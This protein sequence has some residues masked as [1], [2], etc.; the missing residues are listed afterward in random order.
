MLKPNHKQLK[1]KHKFEGFLIDMI[2]HLAN[3]VGFK[4]DLYLVED[5]KYGS[6]ENGSWNGMIQDLIIAV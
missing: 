4:Y 3:K 6:I 5:R 1:G 2:E